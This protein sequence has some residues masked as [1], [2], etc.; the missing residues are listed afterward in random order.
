[1]PD[2]LTLDVEDVEEHPCPHCGTPYQDED[3]AYECCRHMCSS[4]GESYEDED[5]AYRCCRSTCPTCGA[6]HDYSDDAY[7]CCRNSDEYHGEVPYLPEIDPYRVEVAEV[8]GR[9]ARLCSIEQELIDGGPLV[10]RML[11]EVGLSRSDS[12]QGYHSSGGGG[13]GWV[14]VEEDGS[15][16][17]EGGEVIFDRFNLSDDRDVNKLSRGLTKIRQLRDLP[18]RPVRTGFAAGIH[19]HVS[20]K[21]EDGTTLTPRDVTALYEL[22][23]YAEDMLY[24]FSAAGWNRHR[25]PT[26]AYAGYCKPVPKSDVEATPREVWRLMRGDRYYG[27]NFQRLFQ[28]VSNCSCGAATM[29]DWQS[30]DCGAFDRATIEWRVFNSSTLPRTIHAWLLMAHAMTAHAARHEIGTL[31]QHPYG[32]QTASEKRRVL[33]HLLEVLPLTEGEKDVIL[34]AWER[35]PQGA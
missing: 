3:E 4:C 10:A 29:G 19:V 30:C 34:D 13:R 21:A 28:A 31:E 35:S 20:A 24:S 8:P 12:R 14:H 27:L 33:F 22:W 32:T 9:P 2:T 15:L 18:D 5:D 25:Q 23:S 7:D 11:H 26:D 1:M 17:D 6:L 16:P